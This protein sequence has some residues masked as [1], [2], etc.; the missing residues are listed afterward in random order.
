[1]FAI[2]LIFLQLG[3]YNSVIIGATQ[4][5]DQ[6]DYDLVIVGAITA[7]CIRP[8][9]FPGRDCIRRSAAPMC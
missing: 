5:Y 1:M 9:T 7:S 6:I 3:F 2:M 8:G 4:V